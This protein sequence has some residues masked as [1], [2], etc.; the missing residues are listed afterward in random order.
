MRGFHITFVQLKLSLI[1]FLVIYSNPLFTGFDK[2]FF[3]CFSQTIISDLLILSKIS[4]ICCCALSFV[5]I[6][7][8]LF[9]P[10]YYS[11]MHFSKWVDAGFLN[12]RKSDNPRD[13][14][15]QIRYRFA[16]I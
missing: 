16:I 4:S 13:Y 8:A 6:L 14:F 2:K 9:P 10:V 11:F 15:T 12:E 5:I 1:Y 7:E 3:L